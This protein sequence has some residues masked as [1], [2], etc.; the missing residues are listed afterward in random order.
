MSDQPIVANVKGR[1]KSRKSNKTDTGK[2]AHMLKYT[3]DAAQKRKA[4]REMRKHWT[5]ID[6]VVHARRG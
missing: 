4:L 3:K 1:S 5:N 2:F 6:D